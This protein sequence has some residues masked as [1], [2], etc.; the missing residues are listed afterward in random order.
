MA[1]AWFALPLDGITVTIDGETLLARRPCT[2]RA[3]SSSSCS[4][5]PRVVIAIVAA[6]AMVVVGLGFGALGLAFGAAH[7]A[8][9]AGARRGA[10]R[11]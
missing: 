6:L 7:G 4:P 1:A 10:V 8:R 5:S 11:R 2:G 3:P 9:L